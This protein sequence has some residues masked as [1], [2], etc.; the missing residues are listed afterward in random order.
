[1]FTKKTMVDLQLEQRYDE[2]TR[3]FI[4]R[5]TEVTKQIHG[6]DS[7]QV[8]NFFIR[9]LINESLVHERFIETPPEDI[10]EERAKVEGIIRVEENR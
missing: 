10:N 3:Q 2:N 9:G 8:A 5:F 4:D 6:L 7:R 1:M